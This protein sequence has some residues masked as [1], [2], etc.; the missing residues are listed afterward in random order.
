MKS[1]HNMTIVELEKYR[2]KIQHRIDGNE[3]RYDKRYTDNDSLYGAS[4]NDDYNGDGD[5]YTELV[6]L[7][8][9]INLEVQMQKNQ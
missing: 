1:L 7:L 4:I 2:E 8:S 3:K 5:E 6:L 9:K